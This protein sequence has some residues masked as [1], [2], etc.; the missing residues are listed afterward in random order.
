MP[1]VVELEERYGSVILGM[2]RRRGGGR[3]Y[4]LRSFRNGMG[5]LAR[6]LAAGIDVRYG[7]PVERLSRG[8]SV[9]FGGQSAGARCVVLAVPA[10]VASGLL[11]EVDREVSGALA[12]VCYAPIVV[13]NL[14]VAVARFRKPLAGFGFLVARGE[15]LNL[16][17][18]LFSSCLFPGRAP[19]GWHLLTCFMGG[20]LAADVVEWP[21]ERLWNTACS[22]V[23][24]VLG[25]DSGSA[26][27]VRLKRYRQ[28][29]PQYPIGHREWLSRTRSRAAALSGL[30]L[31]GNYFSGVSV[32]AT[33]EH[34]ARTADRVMA[35]LGRAG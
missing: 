21:E 35:Y 32:P 4:G 24:R 23:E 7:V 13:A 3:R 6:G 30:F 27:P 11:G 2:L 26:R 5:T 34:G 16:L 20:A 18:T 10:H 12:E 9:S 33:M 1:Q 25:V 17:G 8:W 28:A 19:E 31:T 22:E 29:I 15:G 14:A